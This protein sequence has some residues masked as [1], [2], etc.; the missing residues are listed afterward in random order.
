M[1]DKTKNKKCSTER[2]KRCAKCTLDCSFIRT[3]A[4]EK[5]P[6][7]E[8]GSME[9]SMFGDDKPKYSLQTCPKRFG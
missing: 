3:I 6:D 8:K 1:V 9:K 4:L 7:N 5:F 2:Y